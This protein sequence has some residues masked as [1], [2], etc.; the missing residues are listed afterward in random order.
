MTDLSTSACADDT[1]LP[2][3]E[4]SDL[5][6]AIRV[7]QEM[8]GIYEH[9]DYGDICHLVQAYG[10]IRESLRIVLRALGTEAGEPR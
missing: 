3:D 1:T 5:A 10:A 4:P 2:V 6:V 7:A 8:L 9:V